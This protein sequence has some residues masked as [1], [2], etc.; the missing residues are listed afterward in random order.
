MARIHRLATWLGGAL[1]LAG[2]GCSLPGN[3]PIRTQPLP[4]PDGREALLVDHPLADRIA[5]YRIQARLDPKAHE[6]VAT[7][8]LTW[9]HNGNQPVDSVPIHLYMNA[10]K[11]ELSVFMKERPGGIHRQFRKSK[12]S[13]GWIDVPSIQMEGQELRARATYGEDETTLTVPLA[14]P[15][16]PGETLTLDFRFTTH[17][18]EVFA[19]TGYKGDFIMV[20]QWFPKIGVLAMEDGK[21][22]WH[23]DTFHANSEFFADFG[24]YDV[25]MTAPD[26]HVVAATGVLAAVRD[27]G[28]G[29][30]A[31]SYHAEDVHDFVLMADPFMKVSRTTARSPY[32][33]VEVRVYHRPAQADYASRHLEAAK[34]TIERFSALFVPYPYRIISVVDP[35]ADALGAG[36]MEY[37]TLVTTGGD[38]DTTGQH[39]TEFVTV[40]EVGHN[41]FQGMLA[42][43]EVDEAFLDEGVNEY[44]DGIVVDEWFGDGSST[45]DTRVGHLGHYQEHR[46]DT[47]VDQLVTP[48][49]TRSYEFAP[50]EYGPVTYN[51]TALVLKTLENLVGRDRFFAAMGLYARRTAFRHPTRADFF[52]ALNEGLGKPETGE[53]WSWYLDPAFLGS[54][55]VDFRVSAIQASPARPPR[56]VFGDG[57]AQKLDPGRDSDE[58]DAKEWDARF[59]VFSV[60]KMRLPVDI[61]LRYADRS[62]ERMSWD[63]RSGAKLFELRRKSR[64]REVVV[65]PDSK[66]MLEHERL[67]NS[68]SERTGSGASWRAAARAGFWEQTLEQMVGL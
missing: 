58:R 64:L 1:W 27:L 40:H 21:Q 7:E 3:P 37:P 12:D 13:W 31:H 65:D 33:P 61:L 32:G 2:S 68:W 63:G 48:I 44:A 51:K 39:L 55:G 50:G 11:N 20:A 15:V 26:T 56:G 8:T 43:N 66:I 46:V 19:R 4:T 42:S 18:P 67:E 62:T 25:E 9:R 28:G 49:A 45:I 5:S 22:R 35:P 10:F 60:G 38:L 41:W 34:R 57:V 16:A 54:G 14:H 17:L 30:R 6:V 52:A 23:C 53:D 59:T 24:I 29:L 36:G 47:D